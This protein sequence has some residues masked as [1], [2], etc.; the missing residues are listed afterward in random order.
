VK[1]H[2]FIHHLVLAVNMY[3]HAS[4]RVCQTLVRSVLR[5]PTSPGSFFPIGTCSRLS[6]PPSRRGHFESRSQATRSAALLKWKGHLQELR[7]HRF[8]A[9]YSFFTC[10]YFNIGLPDSTMINKERAFLLSFSLSIF[11]SGRF[12]PFELSAFLRHIYSGTNCYQR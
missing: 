12:A 1:I 7:E 6:R 5:L 4:T 8:C 3:H 9:I 11:A 10:S 2:Y